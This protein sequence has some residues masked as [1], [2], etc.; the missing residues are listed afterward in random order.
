MYL[1]FFFVQTVWQNRYL[2]LRYCK[3]KKEKEKKKKM[4]FTCITI[5]LFRPIHPD[6]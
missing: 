1:F 5:L 2:L 3:Y 4:L 6:T